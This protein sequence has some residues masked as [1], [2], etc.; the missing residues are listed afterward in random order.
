MEPRDQAEL[1]LGDPDLDTITIGL[2]AAEQLGYQVVEPSDLLT[3]PGRR[4]IMRRAI[5]QFRTNGN[6]DGSAH[7]TKSSPIRSLNE[8]LRL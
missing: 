3:V 1:L 5:E 8:E 7:E 6:G 2:N 4:Q